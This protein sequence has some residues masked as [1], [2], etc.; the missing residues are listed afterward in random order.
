MALLAVA[1][2]KQNHAKQLI[3]EFKSLNRKQSESSYRLAQICYTFRKPKILEA[4]GYPTFTALFTDANLDLK[5]PL[6]AAEKHARFIQYTQDIGYTKK[7]CI[8]ILDEVS[9]NAAVG[10]LANE[11]KKTT[12]KTF[13]NRTR[14]EF[15][16]GRKLQINFPLDKDELV[17]VEKALE[18]FGLEID[19]SGQRHGVSPALLAMAKASRKFKNKA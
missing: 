11:T 8:E 3:T 18:K 12:V 10:Q 19:E 9:L 2:S 17:T 15:L 1:T 14:K 7:E 6:S 5:M 16:N 4:L 13:L